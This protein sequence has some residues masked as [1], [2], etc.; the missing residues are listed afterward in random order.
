[1]EAPLKSFAILMLIFFLQSCV[2]TSS[3]SLKGLNGCWTF[4]TH[5]VADVS[6]SLTL[7]INDNTASM[8]IHYPNNGNT[9]TNCFNKGL[10][11]KNEN[12]TILVALESGQC[13]NSREAAS[14]NLICGTEEP[15]LRCTYVGGGPLMKF[16]RKS[17]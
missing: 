17:A 8:K 4:N 11:R 12:A 2:S 13:E 15:Y 1:M 6:N 7:C 9:P 10:V 16:N 14:S 5:E 3:E